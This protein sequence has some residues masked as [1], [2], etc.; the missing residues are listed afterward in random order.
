MADRCGV[1]YKGSKN[2][3]AKWV[4][5]QLPRAEVFVDLFFGGG[6]VTHA[7]L[8][9]G[10][11]K[12]FVAN[13]IDGRLPQFFLDCCYG[14]YTTES[15]KEWVSREDFFAK[16]DDIYY[17]LIWSFGNNGKDYL[18]SKEREPY[19]KAMHYACFFED[20]T[21]FDELGVSVPPIRGGYSIRAVQAI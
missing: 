3:I 13:D 6:A 2:S 10:K 11:Y 15:H 4:I 1:P 7:G 12:Q 9:S 18:Y 17:A 5:A 21:L 14:K 19:K 8:I 16:I 20:T